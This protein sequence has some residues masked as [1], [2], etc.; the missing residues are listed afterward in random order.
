MKQLIALVAI[1]AASYAEDQ[2]AIDDGQ[3]FPAPDDIAARMVTEGKA[4]Y[5]D[6]QTPAATEVKKSAKKTKVRL[7]ID[8]AAGNA[9]DVVELDAD[10]AKSLENE[11]A[12]DSTKAGISYAMTLPQ[13]NP[14]A[15]DDD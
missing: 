12:A 7:L 2:P 10:V 13:N 9:N 6:P 4:K 8:S 1:A 11:G 5:A 15:S 3:H 14:K